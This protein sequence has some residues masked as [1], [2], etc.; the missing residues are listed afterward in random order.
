M[1]NKLEDDKTTSKI[2]DQSSVSSIK[3]PDI[4][5]ITSKIDLDKILDGIKSMINPE[6]EGRKPPTKKI[7]P[8]DALGMKITELSALLQEINK[9]HIKLSKDFLKVSDLLSELFRDIEAVR[10]NKEE[11]TV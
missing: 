6:N 11:K 1:S 5:G 8:N 9:T 7:D 4:S 2:E 3:M 10:A